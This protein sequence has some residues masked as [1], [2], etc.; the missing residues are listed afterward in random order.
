MLPSR[1]LSMTKLL[2]VVQADSAN[3]SQAVGKLVKNGPSSDWSLSFIA[4]MFLLLAVT[5]QHSLRFSFLCS[6]SLKKVVSTTL[7]QLVP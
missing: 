1:R 4:V 7:S 2:D 6:T 5:V 3:V